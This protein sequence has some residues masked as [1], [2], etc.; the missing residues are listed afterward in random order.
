MS[1]HHTHDWIVEWKLVDGVAVPTGFA[2]CGCEAKRPMSEQEIAWAKDTPTGD[3]CT[4]ARTHHWVR[5]T[6]IESPKG[7]EE[8]TCA[9]CGDTKQEPA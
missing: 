9:R 3:I 2:A 8:Y 1:S 6:N 7:M 4:K 5:V